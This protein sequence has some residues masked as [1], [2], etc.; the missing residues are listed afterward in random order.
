MLAFFL[1]FLYLRIY[2]TRN[3]EEKVSGPIFLKDKVLEKLKSLHGG[4]VA[5]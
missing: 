3:K 4:E 2:P 5:G 1:E